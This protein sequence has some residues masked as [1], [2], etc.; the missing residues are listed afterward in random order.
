MGKKIAAHSCNAALTLIVEF[1]AFSRFGDPTSMSEVAVFNIVGKTDFSSWIAWASL[2]LLT[3][4]LRRL[5]GFP[6]LRG[7][8]CAHLEAS[9]RDTYLKVAF[10]TFLS[11]EELH[12]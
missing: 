8:L 11:F 2:D 5:G 4:R 9:E 12:K 3:H 6:G 1:L 10:P 7:D